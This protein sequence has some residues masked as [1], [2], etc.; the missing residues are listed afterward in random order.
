MSQY[1]LVGL[2]DRKIQKL[3]NS[4]TVQ[5]I[6]SCLALALSEYEVARSRAD[7][8]TKLNS[9]AATPKR[10]GGHEFHD[11]GKEGILL[12]IN[13]EDEGEGPPS[14]T[15]SVS[16]TRLRFS[17]TT[18][19][20]LREASRYKTQHFQTYLSRS[21]L[22]F[23]GR[24]IIGEGLDGCSRATLDFFVAFNCD[25]ALLLQT[26]DLYS[27]LR[28]CRWMKESLAD[29][30]ISSLAVGASVSTPA[31]DKNEFMFSE[32]KNVI[33]SI[34]ISPD[35]RTADIKRFLRTSGG[36][37]INYYY[38]ELPPIALQL[39]AMGCFLYMVRHLQKET[40]F[41]QSFTADSKPNRCLVIMFYQMNYYVAHSTTNSFVESTGA[42]YAYASLVIGAPNFPALCLALIHGVVVTGDSNNRTSVDVPLIRRFLILAGVAGLLGNVVH[43]LAVD[44]ESLG[45][46]VLGRFIIGFSSGEILH[47]QLVQAFLPS[48]VVPA[49]AKVVLY[50]VYGTLAGLLLGIVAEMVPLNISGIGVRSMQSTSWVMAILWII[51]VF[52]LLVQFR[53]QASLL[54]LE[55]PS[56]QPGATEKAENIAVEEY[57]YASSD[58]EHIGTPRSFWTGTKKSE[59]IPYAEASGTF[60]SSKDESE[61]TPLKLSTSKESRKR[62]TRN[63]RSFM[64]RLRKLVSYHVAIPTLLFT[65]F[66]VNFAMEMFFTGTPLATR[67]YF[68][69][70]GSRA[71]AMLALL[72][73]M[74]LPLNLFCERIARRYEERT[75]LKVSVVVHFGWSSYGTFL[76]PQLLPLEGHGICF[77][78]HF[79]F[80]QL[81]EY[82][83]SRSTC[84]ELVVRS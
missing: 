69:W 83:L 66:Y 58:S 32:L 78:R 11:Q 51:Y 31:S 46:A 19:F 23:T 60:I 18:V 41:L 82:V 37:P 29:L 26:D 30:M 12:A 62:G 77:H 45:L 84:S 38:P 50:R 4:R 14:T 48:Q 80:D 47:R 75:I 76:S 10:S 25:A 59:A 16:L 39:N 13:S 63:A 7:A 15:S 9:G 70:S 81:D 53:P 79:H 57:D 28:R 17:V 34:N 5:V 36:E 35:S 43:G 3:A 71:G 40:L 67:H 73:L 56:R 1:K 61:T 64:A 42:S 52:R 49:A 72:V 6:S 54:L 55:K 22:S 2:Y 65:I 8:L 27:G 21:L 33:N 68:E 44:Q 74:V 20:A 24:P